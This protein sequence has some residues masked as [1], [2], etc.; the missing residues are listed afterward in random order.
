MK[1]PHEVP[2]AWKL[3]FVAT[4]LMLILVVLGTLSYLAFHAGGACTSE[5][6]LEDLCGK[7]GR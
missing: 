1:N 7:G 6:H 5:A 4:V 2:M 3:G